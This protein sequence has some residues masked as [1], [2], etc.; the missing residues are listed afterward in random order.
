LSVCYRKA[1][2]GWNRGTIRKA[3]HELQNGMTCLDAFHCR[4]RKPA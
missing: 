2:L 3:M 4:R 1:H